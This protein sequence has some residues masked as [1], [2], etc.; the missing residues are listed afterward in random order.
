L[1]IGIAICSSSV[2]RRNRFHRLRNIPASAELN[3]VDGAVFT[4][5]QVS[6]R[7]EYDFTRLG[8]TK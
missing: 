3:H 8:K 4:S 6:A 7:K 5:H 1:R 2:G